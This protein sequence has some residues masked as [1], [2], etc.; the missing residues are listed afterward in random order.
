M[1]NEKTS[2]QHSA[3]QRS[4]PTWR[5]FVKAGALFATLSG[6]M[7]LGT[8]CGGDE[9]EEVEVIDT[10]VTEELTKG[11]ITTVKEVQPGQFAVDDEQVVETKDSSRIIVKYLDGKTESLTIDQAKARVQPQDSLA[12]QD[13]ALHVVASNATTDINGGSTTTTT[14]S[15]KTTKSGNTTTTTTTTDDG[16][17]VIINNTTATPQ[18]HSSYSPGMHT[19]GYVLM[20][21]AV[22]YYMGKSMSMP[23]NPNVYR[24]PQQTYQQQRYSGGSSGGGRTYAYSSLRST[25]KRSV[26]TRTSYKSVPSSGRS[27]YMGKSS[28]GGRSSSGGGYSG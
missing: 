9:Y 26:S 11:L 23:P 7:L 28:S 27:G 13:T 8:S 19:L 15:T 14:P 22:G 20:G 25:A 6:L 10:I 3:L 16:K 2:F 17:T 21:S 24:N 5:N 18:Y 12:A 1:K 4:F